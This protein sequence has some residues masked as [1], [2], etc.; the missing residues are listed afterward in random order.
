MN[1]LPPLPQRSARRRPRASELKRAAIIDAALAEFSR[2]GLH[3]ARVE[4]IAELA[5]ISKTNLLYYF[6]SKEI[7]YVEVLKRILDQWLAPL[8]ALSAEQEPLE[9]IDAYLSAKLAAARDQPE[10]SR[11][12]CLE[13]MQGAPLIAPVLDGELKQLVDE[14]SEVIAGWIEQGRLAPVDP[15]QLL[16]LL[17]AATQHYA[18]FATQVRAL[19]GSGL[20]DPS[21]FATALATL[22][23]AVL[24]GLKP[25]DG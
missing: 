10:A 13:M 19:S 15:R 21:F 11:L 1:E 5:G 22:R 23:R 7:L 4:T 20:E 17:W 18:D 25:R 24:E 9:A 14:K 12:F 3:G 16:Y 8:K 2:Y 6:S